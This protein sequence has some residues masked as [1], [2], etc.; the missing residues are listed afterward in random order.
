MYGKMQSLGSLKS[1]LRYALQLPEASILCFLIL[2]TLRVHH[3]GG[4]SCWLLDGSHPASILSSL[5]VYCWG[6]C[7]VMA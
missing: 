3:Q 5:W 4:N 1:F 2:H 6:A 7:N